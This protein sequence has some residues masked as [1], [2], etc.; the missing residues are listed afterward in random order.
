MS[1]KTPLT[2]MAYVGL[3]LSLTSTGVCMKR[4]TEITMK[5]I[6]TNP[7]T[8]DN[9]LARLNYIRDAVMDF[10]PAGTGMVCQE[11][12]FVPHRAS[13]IKA[14]IGLIQ[15]GTIVRL[16][17]LARG[18]SFYIVSPPQL[19]K[20]ATGKGNGPKG[21][22]IREIYKRWG[23]D[24]KDDNQAD[25]CV[26][27]HIAEAIDKQ[28]GFKVHQYQQDVLDKVIKERPHYNV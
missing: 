17:M 5:T 24:A 19:K 16:G 2:D 21:L 14:S 8:C 7:K 12:F 18:L 26:L 9:D 6:K 28:P 1:E 25:A 27:A 15:V 13:Q 11:D 3:D 23:I 10:I 4:G 22:V 20:Y